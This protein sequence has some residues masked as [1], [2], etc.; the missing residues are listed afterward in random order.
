MV[1]DSD[2]ISFPQERRREPRLIE[3]LPVRIWAVDDRGLRFTQS[4]IAHNISRS[5]AL[6]TGLERKLRCGDLI[7]VQYV[8]AKARFRIVWIRDSQGPYKV[9]AA[10]QRFSEDECPW[11]DV[12]AGHAVAELP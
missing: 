1:S 5:G 4:A 9:Q 11:G 8:N 12:L 7:W 3:D 10:V 2:E 6:L